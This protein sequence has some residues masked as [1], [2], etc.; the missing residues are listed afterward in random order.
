M[1]DKGLPSAKLRC[2]CG[3]VEFEARGKPILTSICYCD[4]CQK[5]SREIESLPM[6]PRILDE[7]GGSP[8]ILYRRD[9]VACLRGE[10]FLQEYR[11]AGESFTK[12]VVASC[13][14]SAMF[15]DFEKGHWLSL[16]RD[17]FEGQAP[18]VQ[19][20]VQ[21]KYKPENAAIPNDLPSSPGFSLGF[22]MRLLGAKI[23]ML[24]GL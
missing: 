23:A 2:S 10:Q 3:A 1:S 11:Q 6:A 7:N 22:I 5:G 24:I 13:C 9:R 18:P 15:L 21:T 14:N 4:D 8:Y 19:M 16:Y 12:R 20:R 17:R